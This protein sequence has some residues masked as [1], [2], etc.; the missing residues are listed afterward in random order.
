MCPRLHGVP[1]YRYRDAFTLGESDIRRPGGSLP[2]ASCVADAEGV[3]A[4]DRIEGTQS[5]GMAGT[6]PDQKEPAPRT[7]GPGAAADGADGSPV[8][9]AAGKGTA[10]LERTCRCT[11]WR[12]ECL[13]PGEDAM[14]H[15]S[16]GIWSGTFGTRFTK[17]VAATRAGRDGGAG[18]IPEIGGTLG[19]YQCPRQK[20]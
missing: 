12:T 8:A 3:L 2:R 10:D 6:S 13:N 17:A 9:T 19:L 14:W 15:L 1:I 5:G 7:A 11:C 20:G 4:A 16:G 18:A